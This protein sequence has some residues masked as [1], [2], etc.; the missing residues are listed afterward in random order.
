MMTELL[1][2]NIFSFLGRCNFL[3]FIMSSI[4][5]TELF[6]F[7]RR[8]LGMPMTSKGISLRHVLF[9]DGLIALTGFM[10]IF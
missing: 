5:C 7:L 8:N 3:H 10:V 9:S 1:C 4:G 6:V 2:E